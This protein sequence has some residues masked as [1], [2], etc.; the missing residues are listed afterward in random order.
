MEDEPSVRRLAVRSLAQLGYRVLEAA[1]A[2]AGLAALAALEGRLDMIV[3]DVLL[4]G[5]NG[6]EMVHQMLEQDPTLKVLFVSGFTDDSFGEPG[7]GRPTHPFLSKPYTP[8]ALATR[9]REALD[10]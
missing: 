10:G 9:V 7:S 4:P 1:D 8:L 3:S 2:E 5:M 6:P